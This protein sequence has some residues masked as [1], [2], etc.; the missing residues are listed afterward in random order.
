LRN[1]DLEHCHHSIN[2]SDFSSALITVYDLTIM[3]VFVA[4]LQH[5]KNISTKNRA[6]REMSQEFVGSVT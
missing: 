4:V 3:T 5:I 6:L 2:S 1:T